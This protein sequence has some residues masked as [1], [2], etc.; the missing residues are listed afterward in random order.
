MNLEELAR[1]MRGELVIIGRPQPY[2][3]LDEPVPDGPFTYYAFIGNQQKHLRYTE[4]ISYGATI[5][6]ALVNYVSQITGRTY[7]L[8][9]GKDD[10]GIYPVPAD[11]TV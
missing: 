2:T 11:L 3:S 7:S 10:Y 9:Y 8:S 1:Q 5:A 4:Q 6:D